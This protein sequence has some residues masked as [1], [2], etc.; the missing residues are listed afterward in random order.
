MVVKLPGDYPLVTFQRYI[1][2]SCYKLLFQSQ[3]ESHITH[4]ES[5]R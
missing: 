4:L 3:S 5:A 1:A 2:T